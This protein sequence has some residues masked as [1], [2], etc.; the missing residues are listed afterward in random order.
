[1]LSKTRTQELLM[2]TCAWAKRQAIAQLHVHFRVCFGWE[3]DRKGRESGFGG[4]GSQRSK[5]GC[6]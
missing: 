1:M 6:G 3:Q 2:L 4:T 5:A